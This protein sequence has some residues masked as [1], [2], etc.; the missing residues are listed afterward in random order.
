VLGRL[1]MG[2]ACSN[3]MLGVLQSASPVLVTERFG[4]SVAA[5]GTLWSIAAAATLVA[6]VCW[7]FALNR[8]GL[9]GAG[10]ISAILVA[11][12]GLAVAHASSYAGYAA[13]VALFMA[14]DGGLTLVLRTLR[15]LVIPP[16]AFGTTLSV[17]VLLL[18]LPFPLAG[19]L[20]AV[21]PAS[22]L[23]TLMWACALLQV[24]TL[25]MTFLRLRNDPVLCPT[26]REV[27]RKE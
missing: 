25:T 26:T 6:V 17:S 16:T 7:Q 10:V 22:R 2:M 24:L 13:F 4:H 23:S 5:V 14:A 3:L 11:T 18:M 1:V 9:W 27:L 8:L 20:L 21:T 12:A 15:S 19:V